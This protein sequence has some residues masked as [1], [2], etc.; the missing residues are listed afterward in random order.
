MRKVSRRAVLLTGAAAGTVAVGGLLVGVGYLAS[1]DTTG[2]GGSVL[3]DGTVR[4]NAY[5]AIAQD[6]RITLAVPRT[7][8]GQGVF[9]GHAMLLAEELEIDLEAGNV[10]VGHPV[11]QLPVYTNFTLVLDERPEEGGGPF[12]WA[13]SKFLATF[14]LILTGGSTSTVDAW[15]PYRRADPRIAVVAVT[16]GV[17]SA[18]G[19]VERIPTVFQ[20]DR[21]GHEVYRF[22]H[23]RGAKKTHTTVEELA[24]AN[25]AMP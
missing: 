1:I 12:Y 5:I 22:V 13:G 4:L 8:M 18:C 25:V 7:E 14:P 23:A 17:I 20:F 9:T 21:N 2:L 15:I 24:A 11:E 10:D 19:D 6:G 3:A 16:E